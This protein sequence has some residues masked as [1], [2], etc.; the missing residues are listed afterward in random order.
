[1]NGKPFGLIFGIIVI[2]AA[3]TAFGLDVLKNTPHEE[4]V[5]L[6]DTRSGNIWIEFFP[7]DAPNHVANFLNLANEG[8]WRSRLQH[9]S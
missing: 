4:I 2:S 8:N 6:M 7:D 1:M 3:P 5:V 9:R